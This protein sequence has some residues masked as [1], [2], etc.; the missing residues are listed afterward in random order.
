MDL[1]TFRELL[2]PAGQAAVEDAAALHPTETGFLAAFEKVRKRHPPAV[3][4][5][6]LETALLR[7]KARE[8]F[9][10][11]DRF[12]FT[13]EALEQSSGDAVSGYR[14]GRFR[15]FRTVL[16]LCCGVGMD[17]IRLALVG[18]TVEAVDSDPLRVAMGEAN[19]AVAGVAGRV[20]FHEDD[21]LTMPLPSAAAAFV[22]PSRREG[23]HR[24][25]NPDRY[26][27]PLGAV[28]ARFG[29]G[30]PIAAKIAPGV[31]W[32]DIEGHDAEVEF[33]SSGGE[34]REC[35]LWFGPLK[36]A[37]RRA[38]ILPGSHSLSAD[39]A[40]LE[41][42]PSPIGEYVFDPDPAVIRA[43]LLGHLGNELGAVPVDH[44]VAV[45]TGPSPAHSPF[46]D[47]YRVEHVA[48]F[49]ANQLREYLRE[50]GIGRV[51]VLKR[52]VDLDVNEV[53]R[54]L[55]LDGPEHRHLVLTRSLGRT[56]AVVA[57][58]VQ[59]MESPGVAG[60]GL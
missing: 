58:K 51:T 38:T 46:A 31:A 54:K 53:M 55:K 13:R 4:K 5:A 39:A 21:V 16:D 30:F 44:G 9:A 33:L 23:K 8:K 56:V 34:L 15:P 17:A 29:A 41:S 22:D 14:A 49:H 52:A 26:I 11:A 6:A 50:C 3:A 57:E 48:P 40:V 12:F 18:S 25:L 7:A 10:L 45:L 28:L 37:R 47:C 27:P 43:G 19:A 35:V 32:S 42:P 24:F 2:S 60:P 36:T 59:N 1:P 20:R